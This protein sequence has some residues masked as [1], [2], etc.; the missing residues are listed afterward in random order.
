MCKVRKEQNKETKRRE[1]KV[2]EK[3]KYGYIIPSTHSLYHLYRLS[4]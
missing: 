2:K 4:K 1:K 3:L